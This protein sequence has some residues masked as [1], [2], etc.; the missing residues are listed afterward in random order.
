MKDCQEAQQISD[1]VVLQGLS[2]SGAL[3]SIPKTFKK[4]EYQH[5]F[6]V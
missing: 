2:P 6:E 5:F 1:R 4:Y 3:F